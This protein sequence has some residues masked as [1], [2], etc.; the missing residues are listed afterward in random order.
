MSK[1]YGIDPF[2]WSFKKSFHSYL[3]VVGV[4]WEEM[5]FLDVVELVLF[6]F[7]ESGL[8]SSAFTSTFLRLLQDVLVWLV[9]L[10]LLKQV[11][12]VSSRAV[13][14]LDT[15]GRAVFVLVGKLVAMFFHLLSCAGIT[16]TL[17]SCKWL[18]VPEGLC[19]PLSCSCWNRFS[20]D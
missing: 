14:V 19:N 17:E 7:L 10:G 16:G 5:T 20:Y 18:F 15:S 11:L 6:V 12:D 13:L 3:V 8:Y 9:S 4:V 2:E 1:M